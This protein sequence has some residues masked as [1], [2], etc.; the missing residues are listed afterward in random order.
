MLRNC[1]CSTINCYFISLRILV[2]QNDVEGMCALDW[3]L[4]SLDSAYL[5]YI[6]VSKVCFL[7]PSVLIW[8]FV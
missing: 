5:P 2:L 1:S 4:A 6:I 8:V 3:V 7:K